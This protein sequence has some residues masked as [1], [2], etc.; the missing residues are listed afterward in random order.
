MT[1]IEKKLQG[2]IWKF[3]VHSITGKRTYMTFLTIFLLTMPD[4]T[5]RTIG[6]SLLISQLSIF[7]LEVPSG[8]VADRLGYKRTLVLARIFLVLSTAI[9]IFANHVTWFYIAGV[10][11]AG[12]IA[13]A[14]GTDDAFMHDTLKALGKEDRYAQIM[15]KVRS[16][17]FAVPIIFI[18]LLPVIATV[19]FRW[20][21]AFA[22][23]IDIFGLII[24][25]FMTE[26]PEKEH[27]VEEVGVRNFGK[28]LKE[29]V[30]VGWLPFAIAGAL[31]GG[32]AFGST[33]G[34]KNPYQ[35]MIGFSLPMLGVLWAISRVAISGSL[36]FNGWVYKIFSLKNFLLIRTLVFGGSLIIIGLTSNKWLAAACFIVGNVAFLGFI[37][38]QAQYYL[39]YIKDSNSKATLLS[40]ITLMKKLISAGIGVIMGVLA[41]KYSFQAAFLTF[42]IVFIVLLVLGMLILP[43]GKRLVKQSI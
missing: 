41:Y 24:V 14:S 28:V 21:F 13:F 12:G 33:A 37:S 43:K 40:V 15:G 11:F 29:F 27:Q 17:G 35:E 31:I 16:V 34:F 4:A 9:Y 22:L 6:V 20:A 19:S 23:V 5:A 32:L 25:A 18:L 42:G 2:N 39:E 10:F 38:A 1:D 36:L 26:P 3:A 7:F 8:Y 30:S